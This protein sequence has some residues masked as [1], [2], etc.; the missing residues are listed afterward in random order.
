MEKMVLNDNLSVFGF[1]VTTFPEGIKEAFDTLMKMVPDG[2]DRSLYG[3]SYMERDDVRY[4]AAIIENFPGEAEKYN[5]RR[6]TV[7][8]GE[9]MTTTVKDWIKK[10]HTIKDVFGAMLKDD[11]PTDV[12]P[13]VE[14]YI[15][16]DEMVCMIKMVS[17]G[18]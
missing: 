13:A 9:Y 15:N 7:E 2:V 1:E 16:D 12:R 5:C 18:Q 3:I 17:V 11:C 6:Y 10:T 14:W 8:K 4:H